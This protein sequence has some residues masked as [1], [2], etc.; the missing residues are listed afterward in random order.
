MALVDTWLSFP[1]LIGL[2]FITTMLGMRNL[3]VLVLVGA[4]FVWPSYTRIARA[5]AL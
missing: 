5:T 2:V 4:I 3:L 1:A